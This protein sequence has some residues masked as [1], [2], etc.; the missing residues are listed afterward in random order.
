MPPLRRALPPQR[1]THAPREIKRQFKRRA[2]GGRL[3]GRGGHG[4]GA[5]HKNGTM[6]DLP[7]ELALEPVALGRALRGGLYAVRVA[8][9]KKW[10][11]HGA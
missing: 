8:D 9:L 3:V 2:L 11:W 1:R 7:S 4:G 6:G 5:H 10:Q